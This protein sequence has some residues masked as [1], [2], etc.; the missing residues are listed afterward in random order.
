[1]KKIGDIKARYNENKIQ[2]TL[3]SSAQRSPA[4]SQRDRQ[5]MQPVPATDMKL[6]QDLAAGKPIKKPILVKFA[7]NSQEMIKYLKAKKRR[8]REYHREA[9]R[10]WEQPIEEILKSA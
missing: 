10:F 3:F 7:L 4:R 1:M 2:A 9:V 6:C 5:Y 8:D